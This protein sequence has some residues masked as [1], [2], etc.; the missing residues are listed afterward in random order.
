M[1]GQTR[2]QDTKYLR[3]LAF[4]RIMCDADSHIRDHYQVAAAGIEFVEGKDGSYETIYL[5]ITQEHIDQTK[6]EIRDMWEKINSP[7]FWRGILSGKNELAET[8]EELSEEE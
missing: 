5:D 3:Q 8:K 1:M 7:D 2:T 4:Y 6:A